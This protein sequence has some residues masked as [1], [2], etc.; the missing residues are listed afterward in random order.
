MAMALALALSLAVRSMC[1]GLCV[2]FTWSCFCEAFAFFVRL[3]FGFELLCAAVV[4]CRSAA[5]AAVL[6]SAPFPPHW[7]QPIYRPVLR[8]RAA[9]TAAF[10]VHCV[11]ASAALQFCR[12]SQLRF[13]S[14]SFL[15]SCLFVHSLQTFGPPATAA[16]H[17][18]PRPH[19][20]PICCGLYCRASPHLP[21]VLLRFHLLPRCCRHAP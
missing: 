2:V 11:G 7:S 12:T 13:H 4:L 1:C 8:R 14:R 20:S 9:A 18:P 3:C 5:R 16:A 21:H 6:R 10:A 15:F 17:P 19:P